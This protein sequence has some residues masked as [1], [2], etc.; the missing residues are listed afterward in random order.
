MM[1]VAM[2]LHGGAVAVDTLRSWCRRPSRRAITAWVAEYRRAQRRRRCRV[3]WTGAGRVWAMDLSAAPQPIEGQY[4]CVLHVRDLAS[5]YQLAALPVRRGTGRV[6]ADLLRALSAT[7][8]VPLVLKT[9]NGSAFVSGEVGDW[10]RMAGALLLY[11]PPACPRFNGSIEASINAISIRAHEAAATAGH[12]EYWTT[13]NLETARLRGNLAVHGHG[14]AGTTAAARFRVATPIVA[15]ERGRFQRHYDQALRT[16]GTD[17]AR[18]T[19]T[20]SRAAIVRTLVE[21][22]YVSIKREGELVHQ[23]TA[24]ERQTLPA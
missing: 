10:A 17:R 20:Q 15:E 5:G 22:G 16:I 6:A 9:D 1:H 24:Q 18:A 12:P 13:E 2:L 7:T 19:R 21:L 23:L 3:T 11:S 14:G 8:G 4:R